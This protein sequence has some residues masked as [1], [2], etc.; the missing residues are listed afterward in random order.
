MAEG[1]RQEVI[2]YHLTSLPG[3]GVRESLASVGKDRASG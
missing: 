3:A 1:A 2:P